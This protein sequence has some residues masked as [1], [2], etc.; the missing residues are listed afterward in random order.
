[1][2]ATSRP[3]E[4]MRSSLRAERS[5][6]GP[7]ARALTSEAGF[8]PERHAEGDG[9]A[10]ARARTGRTAERAL[11]DADDQAEVD[12]RRAHTGRGGPQGEDGREGRRPDLVRSGA[13]R[14]EIGRP[15]G[16]A[17]G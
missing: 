4:L 6:R 5:V 13:G 16:T 9:R 12:D 11:P 17:T 2:P 10:A 15:G 7:D 8:E 14:A 1:M 3:R